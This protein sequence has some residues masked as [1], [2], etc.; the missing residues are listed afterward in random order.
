MATIDIIARRLSEHQAAL[1]TTGI[2]PTWDKALHAY[3]KADIIQHADIQFGEVG[4][5]ATQRQRERA[6]IHGKFGKDW[7]AN[8]EARA[9]ERASYLRMQ[10][11]DDHWGKTV[12]QT[13]WRAGRELALTPAPT[14]AAIAYKAAV[15]EAN[16]LDNDTDFPG[17]CMAIL[18]S[19]F[20]RLAR[21]A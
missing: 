2:D 5:A 15:M 21:E 16:E 18:R 7:Q 6:E 14:M 10:D 20:A 4:R 12:C 9:L 11:A 8:D 3:L 17:D 19:D 13:Y 1:A